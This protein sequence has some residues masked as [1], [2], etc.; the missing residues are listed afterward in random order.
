M[1]NSLLLLLLLLLLTAETPFW[2]LYWENTKYIFSVRIYR[3]QW[4]HTT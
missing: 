1:L 3:G 2:N 4:M